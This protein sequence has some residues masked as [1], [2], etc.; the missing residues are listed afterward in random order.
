MHSVHSDGNS[1]CDTA[2]A[3]AS[4]EAAIA[5]QIGLR[6]WPMETR[7]AYA[8]R[9]NIAWL[10]AAPHPTLL[11]TEGAYAGNTLS[12]HS[13]ARPQAESPESII[14]DQRVW[15]P[16]SPPLRYGAPE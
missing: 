3:A 13:G 4:R 8:C 5:A 7:L 2:G 9:S 15:I 12:G 16:G 14:T 6:V 10:V 1:C 11:Q